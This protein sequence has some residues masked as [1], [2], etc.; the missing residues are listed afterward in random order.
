MR[1]RVSSNGSAEGVS[2]VK[3]GDGEAD[4]EGFVS[5]LFLC[6]A[7]VVIR[8]LYAELVN[9]LLWVVVYICSPGADNC[10]N[11]LFPSSGTRTAVWWVLFLVLSVGEA[12][13]TV[14]GPVWRFSLV[15]PLTVCVPE[16]YGTCVDVDFLFVS[17]GVVAIGIVKAFNDALY[18][19]VY[20]PMEG[21]LMS[22]YA[23]V[24]VFSS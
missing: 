20:G 4:D 3:D 19:T 11:W 2:E 10:P 5:T 6:K 18:T 8:E 22:V 7:L 14:V 21:V 17:I 9:T 15:I 1:P 12:T 13:V 24:V 23:G 16:A